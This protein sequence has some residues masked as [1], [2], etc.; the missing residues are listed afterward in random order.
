MI[1]QEPVS[2]SSTN[3]R[4]YSGSVVAYLVCANPF[5]DGLL[6]SMEH[7]LRL[8]VPRIG[9][10]GSGELQVGLD[11]DFNTS[12]SMSEF[13]ECSSGLISC[14]V[15]DVKEILNSEDKGN[16]DGALVL[17]IDE[18]TGY[19]VLCRYCQPY[20]RKFTHYWFFHQ[21]CGIS[22]SHHS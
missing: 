9:P 16:G 21:I 5:I 22:T 8:A 2:M 11:A 20:R 12:C 3:I 7:Q 1:R 10:L 19:F 6:Y 18:S 4:A 15:E 17:R 14:N 13:S